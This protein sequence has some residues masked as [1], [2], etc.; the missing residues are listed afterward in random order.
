MFTPLNVKP[1]NWGA[2][3]SSGVSRKEKNVFLCDLRASSEAGGETYLAIPFQGWLWI[4]KMKLP[5]APLI[6]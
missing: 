6:V 2:A 1:F 5:A 4:N 3:Y